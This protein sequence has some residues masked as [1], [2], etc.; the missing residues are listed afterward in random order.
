MRKC[1]R[2]DGCANAQADDRQTHT[3]T[4]CVSKA[5]KRETGHRNEARLGERGLTA[6]GITITIGS[7][8]LEGDDNVTHVSLRTWRQRRQRSYKGLAPT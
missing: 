7:K 3:S 5:W 4:A 2:G 6:S 1:S 8:E